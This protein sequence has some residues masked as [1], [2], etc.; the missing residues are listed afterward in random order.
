MSKGQGSSSLTSTSTLSGASNTL[1]NALRPRGGVYA[2]AQELQMDRTLSGA[3]AGIMQGGWA[4]DVVSGGAA[5][6][7]V[8]KPKKITS[9]SSSSISSIR[10]GSSSSTSRASTFLPSAGSGG[11]PFRQIPIVFTAADFAGADQVCRNVATTHAGLDFFEAEVA[12]AEEVG[13]CVVWSDLTNNHQ[14]EWTSCTPKKE[15][16]AWYC[17][18][19]RHTRVDRA[20]QP[21]LGACFTLRGQR[22][23]GAG[24]GAGFSHYFLPL[25]PCPT[26]DLSS[27]VPVKAASLFLL[28]LSGEVSLADRWRV[29]L[30]IMAR[31]DVK[32]VTFNSQLLLLPILQGCHLHCG[33]VRA[34]ADSGDC[35][36]ITAADIKNLLDLKVG[37]FLCSENLRASDVVDESQLEL[38]HILKHYSQSAS[39]SAAEAGPVVSYGRVSLML[40]ATFSELQAVL[41]AHALCEQELHKQEMH[42][43]YLGT[44]TTLVRLLASMEWHGV[45]I[46]AEELSRVIAQ[47]H[48]QILVLE[49]QA[50]QAAGRKFNVSSP[51]QVADI[52]YNVCGVTRPAGKGKNH[53]TTGVEHLE[54]VQGEH[55]IVGHIL[56]HR[57]LVK[58]RT[59]FDWRNYVYAGFSFTLLPDGT[60]SEPAPA[61]A[62]NTRIHSRWNQFA[63]RTG[64]LSCTEPNQQQVPRTKDVEGFE[65]PINLRA[66]FLAPA[67]DY[68][69][70][71]AD[72]AQIEMRIMACLCGDARMIETFRQVG[73]HASDIY[74]VMAQR[75]YKRSSVEA[76][77]KHDRTRVKVVCLAIMYG[78]GQ[79]QVI[80]KLSVSALEAK[81]LISQFHHLYPGVNQFIAKT[82]Q[83]ARNLGY[84]ATI[85]GYRR[86]LP[87]ITSELSDQRAK[88]ERA[89]V[90][91]VIQGSAS[92]V[93][94]RAMCEMDEKINGWRK[95]M[96]VQQGRAQLPCHMPKLIMSIHD[97]VIY[98]VRVPVSTSV[99]TSMSTSVSISVFVFSPL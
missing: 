19:G 98:E 46:D 74:R 28:P 38:H 55:A 2:R 94:K 41:K 37:S 26:P 7:K 79:G 22:G 78:A 91:S 14:R 4:A 69:L 90:N 63:T 35:S 24:A 95:Y 66:L 20:F 92:D 57:K 58:M 10:S 29:L 62:C 73:T 68:V 17:S 47:V 51:E 52:L 48:Q 77:T 84:V 36:T 56:L 13:L 27:A 86:Y 71:A 87:A 96:Q 76:V 42:S 53:Q 43:S 25:A 70:V 33:E 50:H 59:S 1:A 45:R 75:V 11:G 40:Q 9:S 60:V 82:K 16:V 39:L 12:A 8:A 21:V 32:K 15:C 99:S 3:G 30:R 23:S 18:C 81:T 61:A 88:A 65:S 72:Y 85:A 54:K 93:L 49:D 34:D 6:A 89:A 31:E 44:E 83:S 64:R 80:K 5:S 97:E 67:E